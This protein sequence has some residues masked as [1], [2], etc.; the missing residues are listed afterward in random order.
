MR[1]NAK[2][3]G[4]LGSTLLGGKRKRDEGSRSE[5]T[6]RSENNNNNNSSQWKCEVCTLV[7][8]ADDHTCAA[9]ASAKPGHDGKTGGKRSRSD[10]GIDSDFEDEQRFVKRQRI[11]PPSGSNNNGQN[12]HKEDEDNGA[13]AEMDVDVKPMSI[14][15][16]NLLRKAGS[17]LE[18]TLNGSDSPVEKPVPQ[19]K[20]TG[21]PSPKKLTKSGEDGDSLFEEFELG[22]PDKSNKK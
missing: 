3:E 19:I 1:D 14:S 11:D 5:E 6:S 20:V 18:R 4:F 10:S 15:I 12:N 9:C 17:F 7:N 16:G 2:E 22:A 21:P 13:D 8:E